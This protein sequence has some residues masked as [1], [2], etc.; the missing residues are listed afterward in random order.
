M[1]TLL[2]L[3]ALQTVAPEPTA[4][5]SAPEPA[6]ERVHLLGASVSAGFGL[7][8]ELEV[9]FDLADFLPLALGDSAGTISDGASSGFHRDPR[10][11]GREQVEEALAAEPTAVVAVDFLFWYAY[12]FRRSC[13]SREELLE[14]GLAALERLDCPV[15]VGD[16]PDMSAATGGEPPFPG[17]RTML[18]EAQI[19]DLACLERLNSR[20]HAWAGEREQ[21]HVY[22]LAHLTRQTRAGGTLE[23]RGNRWDEERKAGLLQADLLHATVAGAAAMVV[24]IADALERAGLVAAER[25]EWSADELVARAIEKTRP[26]RERQR[27]RRREAEERRRARNERRKQEEREE[28]DELALPTRSGA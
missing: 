16:L 21:V 18:V 23:L 15:L 28:Q 27:E 25:V 2:L 7:S 3:A 19:P 8:K 24:S 14:V 6:L 22:P 9:Q 12:G 26:E 5:A 10:N 17:S 11:T 13:E 20:I 4:E 1:H